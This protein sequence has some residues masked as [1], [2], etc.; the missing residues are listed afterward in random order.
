M[1]NLE[2]CLNRS[3]LGF[4]RFETVWTEVLV[5]ILRHNLEKTFLIWINEE[6]QCRVIAMELGGNLKNTFE[7]FGRGLTQVRARQCE[8]TFE[9]NETNVDRPS[10]IVI[11]YSFI[12]LNNSSKHLHFTIIWTID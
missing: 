10:F 11:I 3:L 9:Q 6:D 4:S 2:T 8:K 7:R 12:Y 1:P 5:L